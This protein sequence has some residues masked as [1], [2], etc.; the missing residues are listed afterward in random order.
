MQLPF[1]R[2]STCGTLT[3]FTCPTCL[4]QRPTASAG[5]YNTPRWRWFRL[6]QLDRFPFCATCLDGRSAQAR[7]YGRPHRAGD[8]ALRPAL[9]GRHRRA[10]ALSKL[11]QSEDRSGRFQLRAEPPMKRVTIRAPNGRTLWTATAAQL[12]ALTSH[13]RSTPARNPGTQGRNARDGDSNATRGD[14]VQ[15]APAPTNSARQNHDD[16]NALDGPG[17]RQRR[18]SGAARRGATAPGSAAAKP[19]NEA[20]VPRSARGT[21]RHRR[22]LRRRCARVVPSSPA[23]W[24]KLACERFQ[25]MRG[26]SDVAT[27]GYTWSPDHVQAVCTF[28]EQLPHVEGRWS[29]STLHLE[30]WQV[31]IL[32]ARLRLP[33]ARWRP[34]RDDGV[35]PGRAEVGEVDARGRLRALSTW[36]SSANPA[37][38]SSA[39]PRPAARRASCSASCSGWCGGP[40]G[41]AMPAWSPSPTA[42]RSTRPAATR[43]RLTRRARRRTG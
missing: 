1:H 26:C 20:H 14:Q 36:S 29:S 34:A 4:R 8:R 38:R 37:G 43:S 13:H 12:R 24:T 32:A 25:R 7:R 9:P 30:P 28:I 22:C 10:V 31:F 3:V 11:P 40:P 18:L 23:R 21:S 6:G 5:G 41:C 39:A 35:L 19:R 16:L 27:G 17:Y 33:P 2:C 15:R 42:S